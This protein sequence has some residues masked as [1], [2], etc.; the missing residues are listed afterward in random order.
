VSPDSE[1]T[2]P[3]S[4]SQISHKNAQTKHNKNDN[5]DNNAH[6]RTSNSNIAS[7]RHSWLDFPGEPLIVFFS[8]SVVHFNNIYLT[9]TLRICMQGP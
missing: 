4:D 8:F 9:L 1:A 7:H 3:P 5:I 2:S 6:P